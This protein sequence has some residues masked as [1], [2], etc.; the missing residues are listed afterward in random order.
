MESTEAWVLRPG[1]QKFR[2]NVGE[3]F[4]LETISLGTVDDD[5]VLVEPL[6]GSWETNMSHAIARHPIDICHARGDDM[7][8]LGNSGVGR[9][10]KCGRS[11]RLTEGQ[12]CLFALPHQF[13]SFGYPEKLMGFDLPKSRGILAKRGIWKD[14][15]LVPLPSPTRFDLKQ[16]AAFGVRFLT[17]WS[18]WQIAHGAWR[19]QMSSEDQS[20]PNVFGWGGGTSLATVQLAHL[21]GARAA[22]ISSHAQRLDLIST[23][24]ITPI[25][26]NRFLDISLDHSSSSHDQCSTDRYRAAERAFLETVNKQTDGRGVSIFFD[27]IGTPVIRATLKALARQGVVATAGWLEGMDIKIN[28]AQE[29]IH[30]HIHVH[31]HGY[32][33]TD[34]KAAA[35]FAEAKD[36]MPVIGDNERIYR[37]DEIDTLAADF[38]AGSIVSYFPVFEVNP[39]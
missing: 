28:R 35:Q 30:R 4:E 39:V 21:C 11:N 26:R 24:G 3:G 38:A 32:R 23:L 22:M 20:V 7:V 6:Y 12:I 9:V 29:C 17:A 34:V 37:F 36:W 31:T 2:P 19:L 13:D 15:D 27:Y 18:S 5:E 33:R 14:T 1:E 8:V 16:W 10:L 25:D